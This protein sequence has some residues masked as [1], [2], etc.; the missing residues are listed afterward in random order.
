[1]A[2]FRLSD[3]ALEPASFIRVEQG[4]TLAEFSGGWVADPVP[5]PVTVDFSNVSY[6]LTN[7]TDGA[8]LYS[9]VF[10]PVGR[11]G[12][13]AYALCADERAGGFVVSSKIK[14]EGWAFASN[15][16]TAELGFKFAPKA[17]ESFADKDGLYFFSQRG[18]WF[19]QCGGGTG[20]VGLNW[21]VE[22]RI[23]PSVWDDGAWHRLVVVSD[24][25]NGETRLYLDGNLRARMAGAVSSWMDPD[26]QDEG[27]DRA[28]AIYVGCGCWGNTKEYSCK[29]G[30][31][32]DIRLTRRTRFCIRGTGGLFRS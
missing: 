22:S 28:Q 16:F 4:E 17:W 9:G 7:D 12:R 32:N 24:G 27:K 20:V 1:M 5:D 6:T 25:E 19:L 15:S 13:K 21:K 8:T 23:P 2:E 14:H 3:V 10:D 18:C 31:F 29:E 30:L 11:S 26:P